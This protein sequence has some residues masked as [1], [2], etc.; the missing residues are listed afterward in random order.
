MVID[1]HKKVA[2]ICVFHNYAERV[3]LILEECL[4][5]AD[6]IRVIDRRQNADL[7]ESILFLFGRQFAHFYLFHSVD[8]VVRLSTNSENL[9]ERS[10]A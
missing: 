2:S 5:V 3:R 8:E 4:L 6:Y 1:E 10:L 9:A 7:I